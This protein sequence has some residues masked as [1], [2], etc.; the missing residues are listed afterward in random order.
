MAENDQG[1]STG[2]FVAKFEI[3]VTDDRVRALFSCDEEALNCPDLFQQVGE[4]LR[5]MRIPYKP[6]KAVFDAILAKA[7]GTEH[8]HITDLPLVAGIPVGPPVDGN[9]EW[10]RN[11]FDLHYPVDPH[12]GAINFK[13][14]VGDP[15]VSQGDLLVKVTYPKP[16]TSGVDVF[17]AGIPVRPPI[18][19]RFTVG[20]N[21]KFDEAAGGFC[22]TCG[23]RANF[24]NYELCVDPVFHVPSD[25]GKTTGNIRHNGPVVIDGDVDSGF[26]VDATGDVE[27]H[28]MIY[29]ATVKCGGNLSIIGGVN[30]NDQGLL[31]VHGHLH[32]KFLLNATVRA[33]GDVVAEK[34]IY[35]CRI[36]TNS[37]VKIPSGRIVGGEIASTRGITVGEAG[38]ASDA[39][40]TLTVR[41]DPVMAG[42]LQ[43]IKGS[44]ADAQVQLQALRRTLHDFQ[45]Q[46]GHLSETSQKKMVLAATELRQLEQWMAGQVRRNQEI[47]HQAEDA[48]AA[49]IHIVDRVHPG[50]WLKIHHGDCRT[51]VE[52]LGP[53][54]ARLDRSKGV[55]KL[56]SENLV[57]GANAKVEE[58]PPEKA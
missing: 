55:V 4:R 34:E 58:A 18:E 3:K 20:K 37:E 29:G 51:E 13:G 36:E 11:Y 6:N 17:G 38:S 7:R 35:R 49:V 16:G 23:G 14:R 19:I 53:I 24:R 5:I 10:S 21:V 32:A 48:Q 30:A 15:S 47:L 44:L 50:V 26:V 52:M 8:P 43:K 9:L 46:E 22:A 42:E 33:G 31:E 28:G 12:T 2:T 54:F 41:P 39:S 56:D 25:V 27:I 45:K 57:V 40:T 1:P